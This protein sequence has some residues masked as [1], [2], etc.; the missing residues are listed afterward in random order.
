[1]PVAVGQQHFQAARG[2]CRDPDD[3]LFLALALAADAETIVSGDDDLL[4]LTPWRGIAICTP[5]D[6][7]ARSA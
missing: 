7:L 2:A 5:A 3:E 6:Y 1:M 4:I